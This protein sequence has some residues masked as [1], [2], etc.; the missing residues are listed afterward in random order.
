MVRTLVRDEHFGEFRILGELGR[1]G[2]GTV[3][4]AL[5]GEEREVALKVLH[6]A[7]ESRSDMVRRFERESQIAR[8]IRHENIVPAL[9]AG[10]VDGHRYLASQYI[11]GCDLA[12]LIEVMG[13]LGEA[14]ML[15]VVHDVGHALGTIHDHE[16]IHR[17]IKPGNVL[18]DTDG[19]ALLTDFGLARPSDADLSRLTQTGTFLGTPSYA[20]PE[21]VLGDGDD[22]DIRVDLYALGIV[23]WY[24]LT[25]EPPYIGRNRFEVLQQHLDGPIP[26]LRHHRD[27]VEEGT[28][29]LVVHLLQ[30]DPRKRP[31]TPWAMLEEHAAVFDDETL[32]RGR[33]ELSIAVQQ[34]RES[35]DE[36]PSPREISQSETTGIFGE[37]SFD[38]TPCGNRALLRLTDG[39]E[40]RHLLVVGGQRLELVLAGGEVQPLIHS[41]PGRSGD[42]LRFALKLGPISPE[43][44][45]VA[46]DATIRLGEHPLDPGESHRLPGRCK[47]SLADEVVLE[48]RATPSASGTASLEIRRRDGEEWSEILL[49]ASKH[50][51]PGGIELRF[52]GDLL[53]GRPPNDLG[54]TPL[55][56]GMIILAGEHEL[57]VAD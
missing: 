27:D 15:A 31:A 54:F 4:R 10:V 50:A 5:D 29:D 17:D 57:I 36:R 22:I 14:M 12:R 37:D 7:G 47:L 35:G 21:Q 23:L 6:S 3:Y 28:R 49:M 48:L 51:L 39:D 55:T 19:R 2:M 38:A 34:A 11:A 44:E 9:D 45:F 46:G 56:P 30:K 24:G 41:Q 33:A 13:Q 16:T 52:D 42:E 20:A 43:L 18:L 1:G 25:G 8:S 53:L 40:V 26:E 32:A